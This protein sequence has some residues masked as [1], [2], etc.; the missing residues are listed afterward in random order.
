MLLETKTS[1]LKKP[2]I[3][4]AY[5]SWTKSYFHKAN[6]FVKYLKQTFQSNEEFVTLEFENLNQG[7]GDIRLNKIN[8]K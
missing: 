8:K 3:R 4:N 5:G 2:P 7:D 1:I 6:K